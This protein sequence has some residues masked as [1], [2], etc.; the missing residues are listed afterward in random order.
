MRVVKFGHACVRVE[1]GDAAL[2][3]DPGCFTEPAAVDG[4]TGVLVTHEHPDHLDIELL[5]RAETPIWTND[6]VAAAIREQAP[7][8]DERVTV[9]SD[10]EAFDAAGLPVS[11]HGTQHELIH[12]DIP[13]IANSAFLVAG[14]VFHP[15]DSWTAPPDRVDTLLVPVYAPW[16]RLAQA[17][18]FARSY[19]RSRAVAVHDGML[20]D[21]G[22]SVVGRVMGGLLSASNVAYVQTRPGTQL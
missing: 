12:P 16:M 2:V 13:R 9:V 6:A 7:D 19:A 8:L 15:G 20:N 17:V 22:L 10:G 4:A 21:N 3:I 14:S 5:R 11:V 1:D 18:E